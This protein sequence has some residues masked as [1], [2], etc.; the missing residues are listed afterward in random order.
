MYGTEESLREEASIYLPQ[1]TVE[2]RHKYLYDLA[3]TL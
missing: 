3:K 2:M 1:G